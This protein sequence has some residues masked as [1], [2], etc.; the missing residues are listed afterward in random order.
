MLKSW[1]S[2][3]QLPLHSQSNS[4]LKEHITLYSKSYLQTFVRLGQPQTKSQSQS[5]YYIIIHSYLTERKQN[6]VVGGRS[7]A[8]M[9]VLSGVP[10]GSVLGPLLFH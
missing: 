9:P 2:D 3:I 4:L 10:Q 6:V 7:C 8:D 5:S 1:N